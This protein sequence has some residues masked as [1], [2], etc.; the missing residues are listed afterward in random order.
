MDM[1]V[2]AYTKQVS[3]IVTLKKRV[4]EL[5]RKNATLEGAVTAGI[6]ERNALWVKLGYGDKGTK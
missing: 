3:D 2:K 1:L 6:N 4:A 5:E